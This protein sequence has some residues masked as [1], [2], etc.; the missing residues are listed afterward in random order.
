MPRYFF[1]V[2]HVGDDV[3][4]DHS[5]I[6]LP[7]LEAAT[8]EALEVWKRI[9]RERAAGAEDPF[10]WQVA[11]LDENGTALAK[12]PYPSELANEAAH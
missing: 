1:D 5:G 2:L 4:R 8:I 12:V 11:I 7:D 9:L 6:D 3:T 10:H